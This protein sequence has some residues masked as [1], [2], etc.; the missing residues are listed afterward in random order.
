MTSGKVKHNEVAPVLQTPIKGQGDPLITNKHVK[1][2]KTL[3][4]TTQVY[5][6]NTQ[7]I[8]IIHQ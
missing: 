1:I 2:T 5:N 7:Q 6:N 8:T 4:T 3:G